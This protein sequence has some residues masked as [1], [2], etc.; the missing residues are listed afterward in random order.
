MEE[1]EERV[2]I[3]KD[4]KKGEEMGREDRMAGGEGEGGEGL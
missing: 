1:I 2:E 3:E 4:R